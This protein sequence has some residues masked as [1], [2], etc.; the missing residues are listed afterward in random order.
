MKS[1]LEFVLLRLIKF[2]EDLTIKKV[3]EFGYHKYLIQLNEEDYGR[4]IGKGGKVIRAIRKL[5]QVRA[6]KEQV[7]VR[8]ELVED[9]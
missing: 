8:I 6:I 1:L 3:E 2:P 4:V 9:K 5:A 7:R